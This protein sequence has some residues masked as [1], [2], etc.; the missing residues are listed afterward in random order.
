MWL[1]FVAFGAI[2]SA[3]DAGGFVTQRDHERLVA[4][5]ELLQERLDSLQALVHTLQAENAALR[6]HQDTPPPS[7]SIT[8]AVGPFGGANGHDGEGRRLTG[9]ST[10][11]AVNAQQIHE[12]PSGHTCSNSGFVESNPYLL[13]LD[14]SGPSVSVSPT[15]ASAD[16]S[17]ASVGAKDLTIS[18]I[19]RM[20]APL[21]VVHDA[22]CSA[23]PTLTLQL[24]TNVVGKL[25]LNGVQMSSSQFRM[26]KCRGTHS[27]VAGKCVS[28]IGTTGSNSNANFVMADCNFNYDEHRL[29]W[30]GEMI[31]HK[32]TGTGIQKCMQVGTDGNVVTTDCNNN[33]GYGSTT[34]A[35]QM[36]FYFD[37]ETIKSRASIASSWCMQCGAA[38]GSSVLG[39]VTQVY[40]TT[41]DGSDFQ[42]FYWWEP[43]DA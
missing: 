43:G 40:M 39:E 20:A 19:Q 11:I 28:G 24:N 8:S 6:T 7:P 3:G 30:Y 14:S 5:V 37:G 15:V 13:G 38:D 26:M 33:D 22:A 10:Y 9:T 4:S 42:K 1:L 23:A 35:T 2:D 17:F 18:E 31:E 16:I 32:R 36:Y 27:N 29:S 41:C 21:K 12:L 34:E 25:F